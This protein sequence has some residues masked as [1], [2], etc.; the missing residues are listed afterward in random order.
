MKKLV[1]EVLLLWVFPLKRGCIR[2]IPTKGVVKG[3]TCLAV[4][5]LENVLL[6]KFFRDI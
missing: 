3:N 1:K 2:K 4:A 5:Y 6:W